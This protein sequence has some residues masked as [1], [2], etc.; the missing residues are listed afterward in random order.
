MILI[1]K[2][3]WLMRQVARG[4]VWFITARDCKHC[5]YGRYSYNSWRQHYECSISIDDVI[6]CKDSVTRC[7][8]KRKKNK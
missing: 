6:N 3:W 5:M 4:V 2:I 1:E 8:F 7:H